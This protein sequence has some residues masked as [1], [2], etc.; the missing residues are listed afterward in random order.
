MKRS[1]VATILVFLCVGVAAVGAYL[2]FGLGWALMGA[3][4]VYAL[5]F[6]GIV[7]VDEKGEKT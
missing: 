6:L 4:A 1:V 3:G 2:E 7:D 5:L